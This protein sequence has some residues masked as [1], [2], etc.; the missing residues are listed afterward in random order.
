MDTSS[1]MEVYP[2]TVNWIY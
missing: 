2:L 1:T